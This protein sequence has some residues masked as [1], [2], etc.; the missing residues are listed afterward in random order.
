MKRF[1]NSVL[2]ALGM[3]TLCL[4]AILG[5]LVSQSHLVIYHISG[6]AMTIFLPVLLNLL[7][8]WAIITLVLVVAERPGRHQVVLWS[9]LA[10]AIPWL[11]LKNITTLT[12]S[13]LPHWLSM[14]V[15]AASLITF[16]ILS[17]FWRSSSPSFQNARRFVTTA[18]VF[19]S[20]SG[21]FMLGQLL[22]FA[23]QARAL[24]A[25]LALHQRAAASPRTGGSRVIWILFDELSYQQVYGQ[26]FPGLELPA[27][28]AV[29]RQS[30]VFTHVIPAGVYTEDV[31]P[32][33]MT[34]RPI[35]HIRASADG[36]RLSLHDPASGK[37]LPFDPHRTIFQDALNAGYSTAVAGWYNPYCRI[38]PQ[39]LDRC[40]W[41][42]QS[43]Y[44]GGIVP[45]WSIAKNTMQPILQ[46]IEATLRF[47]HDP[48]KSQG[49]FLNAESHINDYR[50]LRQAAD[51]VLSDP[52]ANF[53]FLHMPIPHPE[54]IYDRRK[55]ILAVGRFSY[56]DNLAL[57][58]RYLAHVHSLLQQRGE[59][60]SSTIVMMGDH[61]WRTN[62]IWDTSPG[63]TSED[64]SASHGAQFDDRPA[65]IVKL[66]QQ[67]APARIDER[68]AAIH[69]RALLDAI[70][71]KRI[72]SAT[73]LS[74]W[75]Q[76]QSEA[77][78]H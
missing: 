40:F 31:L 36:R 41:T 60:D 22:W 34:G 18:L 17:T 53:V 55:K 49:A 12:E 35:D 15:L 13:P 30:T 11:L 24:N 25:P 5:P 32:S 46:R 43:S 26:R 27:F 48:A 23:W 10:L 37:W 64:Q 68:F 63:W 39:V 69:T 54:G 8:I 62:L 16:V 1:S 65:Y 70:L 61:S 51:S 19:A 66:P 67:Q 29:A 4:L 76:G 44:P 42:S 59:W 6:P 47:H 50:E 57:A 20:F 74:A 28:D 72:G 58:D 14:S 21:L 45:S 7:M 52:A 73:E 33:L 3:S 38:L 77:N 56:I 9:A 71:D 78:S 75:V 2:V